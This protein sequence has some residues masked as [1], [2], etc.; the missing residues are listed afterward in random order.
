MCVSPICQEL[1]SRLEGAIGEED[2][3]PLDLTVTARGMAEVVEA[4]H[5]LMQSAPSAPISGAV[6]RT[7]VAPH[8]GPTFQIDGTIGSP[9]ECG[10]YLAAL[11]LF[12]ERWE[13]YV[14]QH[15]ASFVT[16][17]ARYQQKEDA[18]D[19]AIDLHAREAEQA[20]IVGDVAKQE[21]ALRAQVGALEELNALVQK[22]ST[23]LRENTAFQQERLDL[24]AGLVLMSEVVITGG[25]VPS[26]TLDTWLEAAEKYMGLLTPVESLLFDYLRKE[27]LATGTEP[28]TLL[29]SLDGEFDAHN[30]VGVAPDV[31]MQPAFRAFA[32]SLDHFN[33][34][35]LDRLVSQPIDWVRGR[36]DGP[37]V[38]I[39][40]DV[41]PD[42]EKQRGLM[43]DLALLSKQDPLIAYEGVSYNELE[44]PTM[45]EE[46]ALLRKSGSTMVQL[47]LLR[48]V[49]LELREGIEAFG[50][51]LVFF[52]GLAALEVLSPACASASVPIREAATTAVLRIGSAIWG[53]TF[54]ESPLL[55]G[56]CFYQGRF[57]FVGLDD[58]VVLPERDDAADTGPSQ[59]TQFLHFVH[60]SHYAVRAMAQHLAQAQRPLGV[61]VY[62]EGH[63]AALYDEATRVARDHGIN[64]IF[65]RETSYTGPLPEGF[66]QP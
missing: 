9:E 18:Y 39:I 13:Q 38:L 34:R 14:V 3:S 46:A 56:G 30:H 27:H 59:L 52:F 44:S 22:Y 1:R 35:T 64:F 60:R 55:I 37:V 43:H 47:G 28:L 26:A 31:R 42:V 29:A 32:R 54:H 15:D 11:N 65:L 4:L 36:F 40:L 62:G 61:M 10:L 57:W 23:S 33:G 41:H 58:G 63:A 51:G 6:H 49:F 5:K 16:Q 66:G 50:Q 17:T 48:L 12:Q 24:Q 21:Q 19:R 7:P 25:T 2:V 8:L 45:P 20:R 53:D